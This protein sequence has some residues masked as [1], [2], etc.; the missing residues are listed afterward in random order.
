MGRA[1]T[2]TKGNRPSQPARGK[3]ATPNR[4]LPI[5]LGLVALLAVVAIVATLAGRDNGDTGNGARAVATDVAQV[6]DVEVSGTPLPDH[7][8]GDDEAVGTK[9]PVAEGSTF[10]GDPITIGNE[11]E[12]QVVFFVAHWCP[13]CQR[14]VPAITDWLG[15]RGAPAGVTLKAVS[16]GVN[17]SA[18]NFPPS[19]WLEREGWPIDTLVDDAGSTVANAFGLTGYPFFVAIDAGGEVVA[20]ASGELDVESLEALVDAARG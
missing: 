1:R 4:V 5:G 7:G 10:D 14:E 15:E 9:S 11:G 6:H 17:E 18:P 19:E 20:R 12:A 8:D 13:H 3:A 2:P 16:T